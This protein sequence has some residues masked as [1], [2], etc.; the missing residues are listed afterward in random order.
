MG[1]VPYDVDSLIAMS[2]CEE[3]ISFPENAF[4]HQIVYRVK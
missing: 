3:V 4:L 2:L 1:Q